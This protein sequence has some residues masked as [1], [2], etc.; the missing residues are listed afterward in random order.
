MKTLTIKDMQ[1]QL[2]NKERDLR[3]RFV[4]LT[5]K[6]KDIL[7]KNVKLAEEI[8]EL[9]NDILSSLSLQRKSKLLKFNKHN[10]YEEFADIVLAT[11]TLANTLGVDLNR[12][13]NNKLQ[14][15]MTVYAKDK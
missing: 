14:K 8:G 12:A 5:K 6:E 4:S 15:L 1:R 7:A 9:S 10:L 13:I 3:I 11:T 2:K